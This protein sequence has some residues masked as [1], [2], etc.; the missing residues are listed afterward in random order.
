M[1]VVENL[2]RLAG[3]ALQQFFSG[4]RRLFILRE[5]RVEI[6]ARVVDLAEQQLH[7]RTAPERVGVEFRQIL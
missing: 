1:R 5:R 2:L 7:A 4:R 6:A 3:I